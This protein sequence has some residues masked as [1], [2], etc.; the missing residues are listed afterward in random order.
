M[1]K[2]E[3]FDYFYTNSVNLGVKTITLIMIAGVL[4]GTVIYWTYKITYNGV[5]YNSKFNLSLIVVLL[6]SI[7]IMLM[8]SSNIVISLGMVGALSVI[9]FRTAIKDSRDTIFIFWSMVEGLCVGSRNFKLSLITTLF[10]AI[11]IVFVSLVPKDKNKYLIIVRGDETKIDETELLNTIRQFSVKSKLRS[12]NR[13]DEHQE[14]I[15]EVN[16]KNDLGMECTEKLLLINGIKSVNW[17]S[18]SGD[19]VG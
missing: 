13:M 2:E 17:V 19:N 1:T 18:E 8:I 7:V 12:Y 11:V 6:I 10:I 16:T 9:R 3:I 15:I 5:A 14:L 4:I